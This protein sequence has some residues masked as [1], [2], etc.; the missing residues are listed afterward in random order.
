MSGVVGTFEAGVLSGA[1]LIGLVSDLIGGRR[2]LCLW[3]CIFSGSI[4]T[5]N[6]V[7]AYSIATIFF[8]GALIGG[9]SLVVQTVQ[10]AD[11]GR[12]V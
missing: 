4:V 9:S 8:V 7:K 2:Y 5:F 11:I 3:F 12:K 1:F 10:S 6:L